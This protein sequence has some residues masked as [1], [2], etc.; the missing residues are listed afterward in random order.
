[1]SLVSFK[2][3]TPVESRIYSD[4]DYCGDV[5]RHDDILNPGAHYYIV[6]LDEDWRGP[7][8]VHRRDQIRDVAHRL[9]NSHPLW[10]F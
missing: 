2:R 7:Q 10:G 9:V 8:R 1:M 6:H 4:G 3:I 5:T